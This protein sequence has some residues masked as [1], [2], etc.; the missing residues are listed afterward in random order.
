MLLSVENLRV[1]EDEIE[2]RGQ[3]I[4]TIPSS[5]VVSKLNTVLVPEGRHIFGNLTVMQ[6]LVLANYSRD[7]SIDLEPEYARIFKLQIWAIKPLI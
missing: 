5:A 4:L 2:L 3:S 1:I 7:K 6:N